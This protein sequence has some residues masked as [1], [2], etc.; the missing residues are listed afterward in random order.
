M[1]KGI[2]LENA[3]SDLTNMTAGKATVVFIHDYPTQSEEELIGTFEWVLARASII[4]AN[5]CKNSSLG[6]T[7]RR[8]RAERLEITIDERADFDL[9]VFSHG[10]AAKREV[11]K[12]ASR[13]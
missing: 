11:S 8:L 4:S 7:V 5:K 9:N 6:A 1:E 13:N 10:Y 2:T 12:S 3:L